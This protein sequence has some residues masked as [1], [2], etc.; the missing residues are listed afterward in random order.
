MYGQTCVALRVDDLRQYLRV[1]LDIIID[2]ARF[3]SFSSD[4]VEFT[5]ELKS[6]LSS[7]RTGS[8]GR[9]MVVYFPNLEWIGS[10]EQSNDEGDA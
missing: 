10:E 2:Q 6:T 4:E 5:D 8:L 3:D 7:F 9:S 1:C